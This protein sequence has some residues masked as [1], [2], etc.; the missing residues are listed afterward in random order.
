M[1]RA[2]KIVLF[3]TIFLVFLFFNLII[4]PLNLDEIWSYGFGHNIFMGLTPYKDFNMVITPLYPFIVS[5]VFH[6]F[7]SNM[8]V[9]HMLN[10][11]L[12]TAIFYLMYLF[13]GRKSFILLPFFIWPV[14]VS[15][16]NYNMFIL[17]LFLLLIYLE[18]KKINGFFIGIV[19]GLIFLTKQSVGSVLL[20]SVLYYYKDKKRFL[21]E[22]IG[23]IIPILIFFVYLIV[24]KS[25]SYFIDLC[26]LGLFDFGSG[27]GNFISP[28]SIVSLVLVLSII[29]KIYNKENVLYN[30][31]LLLFISIVIPIFDYYHFEL[32]FF[33]YILLFMMEIELKKIRL[34]IMGFLLFIVIIIFDFYRVDF[35]KS[36]YPNKVNKFEYRYLDSDS[37]Y[38]IYNVT[39]NIEKYNNKVIIIGPDSYYY[40]LVMDRKIGY[41]DLINTGNWGYTGSKKLFDKIMNLDKDYVFFVNPNEL[42]SN[43]QTDQKLIKYIIDYGVKIEKTLIYDVYKLE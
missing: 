20:L 39:K 32:F 34:D 40:K 13:A 23:F 43:K 5:C 25:L 14:N 3:I 28:L 42:G 27:N 6:I 2:L 1:K 11:L 4:S 31:Y 8:L 19:I 36:L 29:Y 9:F 15:I 7:G 30:L 18:K 26:I 17:F 21:L 35:D 37:L 33:S 10:A 38:T 41:L 22:I 24:T 12:L 16:P